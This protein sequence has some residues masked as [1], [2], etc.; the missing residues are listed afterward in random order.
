MLLYD[1]IY[2]FIY[3][4]LF[5]ICLSVAQLLQ[6]LATLKQLTSCY[7]MACNQQMRDAMCYPY[8]F[9]WQFCVNAMNKNG[10][11][12]EVHVW[13]TSDCGYIVADALQTMGG[14]QPETRWHAHQKPMQ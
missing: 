9:H 4:F 11:P 3:K 2:V 10:I 6:N 7:I 5:G 14:M 12:V 8:R 13:F 1:F